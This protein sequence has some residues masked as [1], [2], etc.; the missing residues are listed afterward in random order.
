MG[1]KNEKRIR[2]IERDPN[3]RPDAPPIIYPARR[4]KYNKNQL[5]GR[6][7]RL[8]GIT[9]E[10]K[11]VWALND[12]G[13]PIC[14]AYERDGITNRIIPGS[15]C[16]KTRLYYN[17]RCRQHGGKTPKLITESLSKSKY[18]ANID[19]EYALDYIRFVKNPDILS[20]REDIGLVDLRLMLLSR[21]MGGLPA[22]NIYELEMFLDDVKMALDALPIEE[23]MLGPVDALLRAGY[24]LVKTRRVWE[25][26][27]DTQ[28]HRRK[29]TETEM[30]RVESGLRQIS[31][32]KVYA[33]VTGILMAIRQHITDIHLLHAIRTDIGK[34]LV[35]PQ[36]IPNTVVDGDEPILQPGDEGNEDYPRI[37]YTQDVVKS[38][39]G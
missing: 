33:I 20:M 27:K 37:R 25:E 15:C 28:E 9:E 38:P 16:Q 7:Q 18:L 30:K 29:L 17:G 12:Q 3:S 32:E 26:I 11:K 5:T 36:D 6:Q 2:S 39:S 8:L 13:I 31:T 23:D 22:D 21:E 4:I 10:G 14:A 1:T 34:L 24:R 19:G 35:L